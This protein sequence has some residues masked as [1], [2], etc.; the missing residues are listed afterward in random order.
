MDDH[1]R[2]QS[3]F[4]LKQHVKWFLSLSVPNALLRAVSNFVPSL[5]SGRWP[6]PARL[7]EVTGRVGDATFVMLDPARCENA[8]ELFWGKGRRP[9]AHDR[10]ALDTVVALANEADVFLDVG[11]YTGLFTLAVTAFDPRIRAHAFEIVPGVARALQANVSRNGIEDRVQVHLEGLGPADTK[12]RMPTGEGGS[13]LPSF[14]STTMRFE[15]GELIALRSLDSVGDL[16]PPGARVV[17]KVDVEGTEN[18]VFRSGQRFLERFRPD[19][20]CEV[21]FDRADAEHLETLLAPADLVRYLVTDSALVQ[22]TRIVPD[23]RYRDWLFTRRSPD[24]L[25]Q[26]GLAVEPAN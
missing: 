1:L 8:K 4:G 24:E 22:H 11:A 2:R 5:R 19:I 15:D 21:L 6:A 20:L 18:A 17:I 9:V 14:Y 13:A 3:W 7:T 26:L 23:E 10:L 16:L 12:V 25:T